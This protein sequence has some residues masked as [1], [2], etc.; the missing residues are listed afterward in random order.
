MVL[1]KKQKMTRG[2]LFLYLLVLGGIVAAEYFGESVNNA[3]YEIGSAVFIIIMVIIIGYT[4]SKPL[5]EQMEGMTKEE[6][7][8]FL[9]NRY[10]NA[11]FGEYSDQIG[12]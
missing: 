5:R 7:T 9:K 10:N 3:W 8:E 12:L 1:K 2:V 6:R 4:Q 11:D